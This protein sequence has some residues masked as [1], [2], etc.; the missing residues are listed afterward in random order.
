MHLTRRPSARNVTPKSFHIS[1]I[2]LHHN[3]ILSSRPALTLRRTLRST[4]ATKKSVVSKVAIGSENPPHRG[5]GGVMRPK[6]ALVR[7]AVEGR[8]W[9]PRRRGLVAAGH[10]IRRRDVDSQSLSISRRHRAVST[11]NAAGPIDEDGTFS[12]RAWAPTDA[13]AAPAI[14]PATRMG[15]GV[16]NIRIATSRRAAT[17]RFSPPLTARI[18]PTRRRHAIPPI[19]ACCS[20]TA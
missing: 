2:G 19:T 16:E 14:R 17:I 8:K 4:L 6:R 18:A 7:R 12:S 11:F 1:G 13:P 10:R 9:L 5:L 3:S 20:R 15:L